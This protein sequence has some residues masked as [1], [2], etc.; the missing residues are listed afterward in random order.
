MRCTAKTGLVNACTH[1]SPLSQSSVPQH[2]TKRLLGSKSTMEDDVE[3]SLL[4]KLR[5]ECGYQFTS[6]LE[7]MFT[8]MKVDSALWPRPPIPPHPRPSAPP[9]ARSA[10]WRSSRCRH[11]RA[12]SLEQFGLCTCCEES[13]P[14][15]FDIRPFVCLRAS[16]SCTA[17]R[18]MWFQL[19]QNMMKNFRDAH[20]IS[21]AS[22][23]SCEISV[24][25]LTTGCWPTL[26]AEQ[27]SLIAE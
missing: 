23:S 18:S 14:A 10:G 21:S 6:K 9:S 27:V 7:H 15:S 20:P 3:R 11:H 19:S 8:D 24:N 25:V 12:T 1:I 13:I 26:A 2:L 4:L 5:N 16:T 22:P 17:C